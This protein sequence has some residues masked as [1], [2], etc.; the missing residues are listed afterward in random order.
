MPVDVV[1][2]PL[3]ATVDTFTLV[4]WYK[5]EGE[6]VEKDELLFAVETDKAV[7]DVE[8]PAS[9]IIQQVSAAPGDEIAALSRIAVIAAQGEHDVRTEISDKIDP[10][11]V[12]KPLITLSSVAPKGLSLES[13]V[14]QFISP[15]AKRL[16]EERRLDWR[17]M[18]GSGPEGAIIE[19]DVLDELN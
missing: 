19:R 10:N 1:V 18:R 2:P 3:G 8:S 12:L 4:A 5:K 15:R 16:A 13:N 6:F 7:L 17:N 11:S 9:G 14:R